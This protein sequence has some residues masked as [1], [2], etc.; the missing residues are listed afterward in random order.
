[1]KRLALLI[2]VLLS[3]VIFPF[4]VLSE[5][6]VT[7]QDILGDW[8]VNKFIDADGL[9]YVPE[10]HLVYTFTGGDEFVGFARSY[11]KR[12]GFTSQKR[13]Q[14]F[15]YSLSESVLTIEFVQSSGTWSL[16]SVTNKF[17]FTRTHL[18]YE[19]QRKNADE[20][21]LRASDA[22]IYFG[23]KN[24]QSLPRRSIVLKKMSGG[25]KKFLRRHK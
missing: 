15:A 14:C 6:A 19:V 1:M 25:V 21:L 12:W 4:K 13:M 9:E 24:S 23:H 20:L 2:T 17:T 10:E 11:R 7:L 3:F 22:I 18:T 8:K 16:D 5:E